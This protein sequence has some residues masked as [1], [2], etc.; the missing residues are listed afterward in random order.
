L[1][2][3]SAALW[4]WGRR[5]RPLVEEELC[6]ACVPAVSKDTCTECLLLT[7]GA[8]VVGGPCVYKRQAGSAGCSYACSAGLVY[9]AHGSVP[10]GGYPSSSRG[11]PS[12]SFQ[13]AVGTGCAVRVCSHP[14]CLCCTPLHMDLPV[15]CQCRPGDHAGQVLCGRACRLEADCLKGVAGQLTRQCLKQEPA[16]AVC[17]G[18]YFCQHVCCVHMAHAGRCTQGWRSSDL[19]NVCLVG[20]HAMLH[21]CAQAHDTAPWWHVGIAAVFDWCTSPFVWHVLWLLQHRCM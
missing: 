5:C 1:R 17:R 6:C 2:Q 9:R 7:A 19:S 18:V 14:A 3:G 21:V 16:F 10:V 13:A 11:V 20:W 15:A 4:Q 12:V 8:G